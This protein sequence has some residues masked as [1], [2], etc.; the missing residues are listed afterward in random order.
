MNRL[1]IAARID[2]TLLKPEATP[3]QVARLCSEAA[4]AN[5]KTVCV[6]PRFVAQCAEALRGTPVGVCTVIG[7]PLGANDTRIKVAEARLALDDGATELDM[8]LWVGGVI[9]GELAT[10]ERD[11]RA[12]REVCQG[13]A[14]LKVI[15]ETALLN[16]TQIVAAC[17]ATVQ[18]GAQWVE[19]STGFGPGGAKVAGVRL[20]RQSVEAHGLRVKASGGIRTLAD[21]EKMCDAGAQRIG[22]SS[23]VSI[24]AELGA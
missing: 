14:E 5:F 23:G 16:E 8:V 18:A 13:R 2:H 3:A 7:F 9:G 12:L 11:I 20:M 19:T 21:F 22:T 4:H 1:E 17:E 15:L 6:N 10:V 24:L